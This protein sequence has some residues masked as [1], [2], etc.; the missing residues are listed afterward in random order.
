MRFQVILQT[1]RFA[2][3]QHPLFDLKVKQEC[4]HGY[5]SYPSHAYTSIS[6][7]PHTSTQTHAKSDD[8]SHVTTVA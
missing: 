6:T 1:Q 7:L 3:Q 5:Y 4:L 2:V 8:V